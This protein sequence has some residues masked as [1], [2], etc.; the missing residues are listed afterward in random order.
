MRL[1][2]CLLFQVD[3]YKLTNIIVQKM[4][5]LLSIHGN[6]RM[7]VIVIPLENDSEPLQLGIPTL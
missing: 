3:I 1:S 4:C 2:S 5:E 7:L 6:I